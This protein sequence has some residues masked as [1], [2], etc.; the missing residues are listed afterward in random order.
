MKYKRSSLTIGIHLILLILCIEGAAY[1][2][3]EDREIWDKRYD[4]EEY[5]FGR[6]PNTFLKEHINLLP[7]GK[8]LELAM[9]EGKDAVFLAKNGYEVDGCDIS[10]VAIK[11]ADK[12]AEENSVKINAL[13][14][15]LEKYEI[16]EGKY[17]LITCFYYLQGSLIPQMKKGLRV[18]GMIVYETYTIDNLKLGFP[19]GPKNEAFL[20]KHNELLDFFRD[21]RVLYYR[22]GVIDNQK[23]IASLI[24]QKIR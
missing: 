12:L 4:T 11:K 13:V 5:L 14:V 16:P 20:L 19:Y 10:E 7:K 2:S 8:A 9:G 15:D 18:G 1:P 6:E 23:A 22:E 24:A 21:F 3:E 17:D